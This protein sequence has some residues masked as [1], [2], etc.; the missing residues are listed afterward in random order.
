MIRN[1]F[2]FASIVMTLVS[3][4]PIVFYILPRQLEEVRRDHDIASRFRWYIFELELLLAVSMIPGLPRAF[5]V[6]TE[7]AFNNYS[8]IASVTNRVPYVA[9][10]FILIL[11]YNY[12]IGKD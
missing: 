2:V 7:P 10:T 1:W 9:I 4:V 11:M 8:K 12:K 5:Q 6:L 3:V